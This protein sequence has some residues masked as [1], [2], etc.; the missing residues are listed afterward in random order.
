[1]V[2][3]GECDTLVVEIFMMTR[4]EFIKNNVVLLYTKIMLEYKNDLGSK[5]M[6]PFNK[7]HRYK[8]LC[9]DLL[10]TIYKEFPHFYL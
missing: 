2:W 1:M 5:T 7:P 6:D 9:L 10:I 4:S 8:P 3:T